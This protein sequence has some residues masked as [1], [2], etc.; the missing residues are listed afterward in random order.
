MT[1]LVAL[2]GADGCGKSCH[3][4]ALAL[5]LRTE[6]IASGTYRHPKPLFREARPWLRALW[7]ATQRAEF[8]EDLAAGAY[9]DRDVIVCDRWVW[10]TRIAGRLTADGRA[11]E[12]MLSLVQAELYALP[13]VSTILLTAPDD[14]IAA[15][16]RARPDEVPADLARTQGYYS[17]HAALSRWPV[18]N[19]D[20]D[21]AEVTRELVGIVRGM[22]AAAVPQGVCPAPTEGL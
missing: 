16:L 6:G 21:A 17:A 19:T 4:H 18:V 2:E 8:A 7:Y 13:S 5:A 3:A 1:L 10:S 15:R 14:V 22:L 11:R 12:A 20:R 9:G